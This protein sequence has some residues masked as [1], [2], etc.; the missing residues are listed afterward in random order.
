MIR[1]MNGKAPRFQIYDLR[2]YR[3]IPQIDKLPDDLK[4]EMEVVA[5]VLPFRTNSHVVEHLI[6]WENIPDDPMF[7]LTFP[8]RDMLS[9][10]HFDEV[11]ALVKR[12]AGDAEMARTVNRIRWDLNPQPAGQLE[13]NVPRED[14]E[15][16]DGM[17]H[18]YRET[19]LFFPSQGQTCHA[20]C[21]FCFRWPQFVGIDEL[22]F[23]SRE[24]ESLIRYLED[25]PQV[26]DVLFT[27]GDPMVMRAKNLSVYIDAL[28]KADLPNLHTIRIGTK[29]L[30]YWP[31]K[32]LTDPDAD[33]VLALFERV[34]R[35]GKHL[36]IMAH[37]SHPAELRPDVVSK[38]VSRIRGTGAKVYTQSPILRNINDDPDTWAAMWRRQ[39]DLGM[40]PYY[41]FMV[42]D[43]GVQ[44][45]FA[46]PLVRA[47]EIF[48]NAYQQVSGICRTVRGP[49]MSAHPGKV[50]VLGVSEVHGEKIIALQF[51]Q[52]RNPDWVLRPFFARYDEEA[53]WL[54]D[55]EPAFGEEAFFFEK[56]LAQLCEEDLPSGQWDEM[57]SLVLEG[58]GWE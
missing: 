14:D 40:V 30:A 20:Y 38:A 41:M 19:V 54:D 18:K 24:V 25:N 50:H 21:T 6:Q 46:V 45:F 10:D 5:R 29:S 57:E 33:D 11:A 27:G 36:A 9:P 35:A 22:K 4:F 51:L 52:G 15:K 56:E 31:Y 44:Q 23:A 53:I 37:C 3:K 26:T 49:S 7:Q 12:G 58:V 16:L 13:H 42:R 47:W 8:Q 34:T 17:Q 2:N 28:L 43:T 1:R 32:Y 39:V 48:Q 55:L